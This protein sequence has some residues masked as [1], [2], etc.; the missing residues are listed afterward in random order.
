[1]D[2][3]ASCSLLPSAQ[4]S[5]HRLSAAHHPPTPL[6]TARCPP[7]AA[8]HPLP[9]AHCT[10]LSHSL[11]V[12]RAC[13]TIPV[14]MPIPAASTL[15]RKRRLSSLHSRPHVSRPC[16]SLTTFYLPLDATRVL[17]PAHS[18]TALHNASHLAVQRAGCRE[19]RL[20][21]VV[22]C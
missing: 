22:A 7:P 1:M 17:W 18:P 9:S 21:L 13:R 12:L 19:T 10:A 11:L 16:S 2:A 3:V 8:H 6:P 5:V 14:D 4:S 20:H 15:E